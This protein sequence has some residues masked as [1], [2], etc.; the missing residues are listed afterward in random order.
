MGGITTFAGSRFPAGNVDSN[1]RVSTTDDAQDIS[2]LQL[3]LDEDI[4][5][6]AAISIVAP[7]ADSDGDG[8]TVTMTFSQT[9]PMNGLISMK[10]GWAI[11]QIRT[12]IMTV[13]GCCRPLPS[14]NSLLEALGNEDTL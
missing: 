11:T 3:V 8:V 14:P 12:M 7:G 6:P 1:L 13:W 9:I 2:S 5:D 10:M 4:Y